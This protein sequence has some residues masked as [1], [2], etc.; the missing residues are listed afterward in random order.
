MFRIPFKLLLLLVI[1]GVMPV[2]S[3]C[4]QSPEMEKEERQGD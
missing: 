2:L 3:G 4:A 1:V